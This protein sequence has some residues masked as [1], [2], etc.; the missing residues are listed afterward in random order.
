MAEIDTSEA[1]V[2]KL[3][4]DKKH[5]IEREA[6]RFFSHFYVKTGVVG[7]EDILQ[8]TRKG[9]FITVGYFNRSK[10]PIEALDAYLVMGMQSE[11]K[12]WVH[13]MTRQFNYTFDNPEDIENIAEEIQ[14]LMPSFDDLEI[15]APLSDEAMEFIKTLLSPPDELKQKI[16]AKVTGGKPYANHI[17]PV[18]LAWM[19]LTY[20]E[21][22]KIKE[23]LREKC[24]WTAWPSQVSF[25]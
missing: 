9:F 11:L 7:Y 21:F 6:N 12:N 14:D 20:D 8:E 3:F 23:E 10:S 5:L 19:E 2:A 15:L 1:A 24:K 22:N 4:E 18:M 13:R 16:V 17:L 25:I